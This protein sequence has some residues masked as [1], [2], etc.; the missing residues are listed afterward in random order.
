MRVPSGPPFSSRILMMC[1]LAVQLGCS[2]LALL[3][4]LV[5]ELGW[6]LCVNRI[7]FVQDEREWMLNGTVWFSDYHALGT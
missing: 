6:S 2:K 7:R 5:E 1:V 4:R 3:Y